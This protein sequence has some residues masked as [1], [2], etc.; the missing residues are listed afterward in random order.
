[1]NLFVLFGD[2][3]F[4]RK[5]NDKNFASYATRNDAVSCHFFSDD[6]PSPNQILVLSNFENSIARVVQWLERRRK[7]L[8]ILA[9][10]VRIP[11][12]D[13]GAGPSDESVSNEASVAVGVA[14]NRTLTGK[15]H[16]Y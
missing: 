6:T 2:G 1:M 9:S 5:K 15:S 3:A 7:D 10:L 4:T 12:L 16:E 11:L 14:R 8:M 13:V